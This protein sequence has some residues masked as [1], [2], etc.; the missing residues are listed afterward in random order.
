MMQL[1][2][3]VEGKEDTIERMPESLEVGMA[4][5]AETSIAD[6]LKFFLQSDSANPSGS[7]NIASI[8]PEPHSKF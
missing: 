7:L 6:L 8:N 3:G 2:G 4:G 5:G 1:V